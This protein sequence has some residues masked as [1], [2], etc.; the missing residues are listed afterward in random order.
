MADTSLVVKIGANLKEFNKGMAE[1]NKKIKEAFSPSE[2]NRFAKRLLI[3]QIG[4]QVGLKALAVAAA[5]VTDNYQQASIAFEKLIGNEKAARIFTDQLTDFAYSTPFDYDGLMKDAQALYQVGVAGNQIIPM[6]T[7]FSDAAA[8]IGKGQA[9]IDAMTKAIVHMQS[10]G[11]ADVR[12][13]ESINRVGIPAWKM[14]AQA[15]NTTEQTAKDAVEQHMVSASQATEILVK[16]MNDMYAGMMKIQ[17]TKTFNGAMANLKGNVE[18]TMV[19]IGRIISDGSGVIPAI[20]KVSDTFATFAKAVRDDGVYEA[21]VKV[22]GPKMV[23]LIAGV[24]VAITVYDIPAIV[25]LGRH[26]LETAGSA[27]ILKGSLMSLT[28][29]ATAALGA[30][31]ALIAYKASLGIEGFDVDYHPEGLSEDDEAAVNAAKAA[32]KQGEAERKHAKAMQA[33][34]EAKKAMEVAEKKAAQAAANTGTTGVGS[35]GGRAGGGMSSGKSAAEMEAEA[36]QRAMR[37]A[38]DELSGLRQVQDAMKESIALRKAYMTA[39]ESEAFEMR[40]HHEDAVQKIQDRWAEFET[41]YIG[42]SD[43]ERAR[44]IENLDKM[45]TAYEINA[46]GRLSLATQTAADIAAEEQRYARETA[47]YY[48]QCKDLMAERDEIFRTNSLEALEEFLTEENALRLNSYNTQQSAMQRFYENWLEANKTAKDRVTEIVL[49]TQSAFEGFFTDVLTGTKSF[50]DSLLDLVNN[51]LKEIM[52]SIAKMM[53]SKIVNSFL[54]MLFPGGG[55]TAAF[56]NGAT[57]TGIGGWTTSL[58]F[59]TGGAVRGAGSGT[60]DSIP[61]WLSNGEYVMSADTVSRL[62]LPFLNALNRGQAPHFAS[63]GYV[64]GGSGG[65]ASAP[66]VVNIY[67]ETGQQVSAKRAETKFDGKSYVTSVWLEA[68]SNNEGGMRDIL[69]GVVTA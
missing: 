13:F 27:E 37:A 6:L 3:T 61:A 62:G 9:E 65:A 11:E 54:S 28:G 57:F 25:A 68:L 41:A 1:F 63:G 46:E 64:G 33:A 58:D 69:K 48:I 20:N 36:R 42:M 8:G 15:M 7:A 4:M 5:K 35:S 22:F 23:A 50:G 49:N 19:E 32:I 66:A 55:G 26:M 44:M 60:S 34:A 31:A 38:Q 47:E 21:F 10:I 40:S 67:N 45:G 30:L 39:A 16:G 53:A 52:S 14:L 51:I 17:E 24:G 12:A 2:L 29:A 56:H 43:E 59:A 18:H